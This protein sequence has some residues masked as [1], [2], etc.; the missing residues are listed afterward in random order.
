MCE[1]LDRGEGDDGECEGESEGEYCVL[2]CSEGVGVSLICV[3][4]FNSG[5]GLLSV[6]L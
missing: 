4:D 3:L 1:L 5:R 2:F 6:A